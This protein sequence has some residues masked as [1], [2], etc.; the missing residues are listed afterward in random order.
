MKKPLGMLALLVSLASVALTA[1]AADFQVNGPDGKPLPLVMVTRIATQAPAVDA[2]DNGYAA[3]GKLQQ[4][5][6][7]STRFSDARGHVRLPDAAGEYRVRLRKPGFKDHLIEP[8]ALLQ[9]AA[10]RMEAE[11]DSKAL[12]EQRPDEA[13]DGAPFR[14]GALPQFAV[15]TAS[16]LDQRRINCRSRPEHFERPIIAGCLFC[17]IAAR[18]P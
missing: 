3:P 5:T 4:G 2:S 10:W 16:E 14:G 17:F 1:Q 18:K 11:T 6:F 12:A 7:E 8:K 13:A 9:P 15:G